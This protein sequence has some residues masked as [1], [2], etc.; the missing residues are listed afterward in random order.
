MTRRTRTILAAGLLAFS[1]TLGA[2]LPAAAAPT[3][4]SDLPAV[5]LD[6]ADV[7]PAEFQV[8][9]APPATPDGCEQWEWSEMLRSQNTLLYMYG[10][11]YF[12]LTGIEGRANGASTEDPRCILDWT[13]SYRNPH[14]ADDFITFE[15]ILDRKSAPKVTLT[16]P[17]TPLPATSMTPFEALE[18]VRTAGYPGNVETVRLAPNASG[19]AQFTATLDRVTRLSVDAD[20]GDVRN[21]AVPDLPRHAV[22][23]TAGVYS[24]SKVSAVGA[25]TC[26]A[27]H[28]YLLN[29][30][31]G[32]GAR[33][34]TVAGGGAHRVTV[35]LYLYDYRGADGYVVGWDEAPD[36]ISNKADG[37]VAVYA[38][39]TSEKKQAM[40]DSSAAIR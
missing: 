19:D 31:M 14:K 33:G 30:D 37:E 16:G 2:S 11:P 13:F 1:A 7:D 4:G 21:E 12:E 38:L 24:P 10:R 32:W 36:G 23:V 8:E 22:T 6:P 27:T 29:A 35:K 18:R 15:I 26:P 39:C 40:R 28:P 5:E 17:S 25:V 34:A 20:T 3:T 9:L